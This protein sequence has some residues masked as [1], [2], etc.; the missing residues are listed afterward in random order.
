MISMLFGSIRQ[1]YNDV[2][3]NLF[4]AIFALNDRMESHLAVLWNSRRMLDLFR[5]VR[6]WRGLLQ[7]PN[8]V[9]THDFVSLIY[10]S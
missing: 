6:G 3:L 10:L 8:H 1:I 2:L 4:D 5:S 9:G 7:E